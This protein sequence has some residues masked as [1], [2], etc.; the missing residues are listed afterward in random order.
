LGYSNVAY[1]SNQFKKQTGLTPSFYKS[2][3]QSKRTN[4]D[5]L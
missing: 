3:K 1:L 4:L 2:L 5:D